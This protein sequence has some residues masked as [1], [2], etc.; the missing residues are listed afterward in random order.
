[1]EQLLDEGGL[2]HAQTAL[3]LGPGGKVT[4]EFIAFHFVDIMQRKGEV[5]FGNGNEIHDFA[6]EIFIGNAEELKT[7]VSGT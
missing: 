7:V 1:M 2:T 3:P 6:A 5:H 4:A